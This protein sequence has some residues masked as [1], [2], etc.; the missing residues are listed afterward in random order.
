[1]MIRLVPYDQ[2]F[3][4]VT[5]TLDEAAAVTDAL[6]LVRAQKNNQVGATA[7]ALRAGL[8]NAMERAIE[9]KARKASG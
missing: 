5:L 8:E 2:V 7:D 9:L 1:M 4:S 3:L 6:S